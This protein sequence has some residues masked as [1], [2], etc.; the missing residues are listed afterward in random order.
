MKLIFFLVTS[1]SL[2]FGLVACGPSS[3]GAIIF[4]KGNRRDSRNGV[5]GI[6]Q[7]QINNLIN[8]ITQASPDIKDF[9]ESERDHIDILM[10]PS[11]T[12]NRARRNRT[13]PPPFSNEDFIRDSNAN[14]DITLDENDILKCEVSINSSLD[15][16]IQVHL[17]A[18]QLK[19]C[20]VEMEVYNQ[21]TN[22]ISPENL[23]DFYQARANLTGQSDNPLNSLV[24]DY[25]IY[26]RWQAYLVNRNLIQANIP[27][28]IRLSDEMIIEL[29]VM[30]LE[31]MG[32]YD[33]SESDVLSLVRGN[34]SDILDQW[35]SSQP[36]TSPPAEAS[37]RAS[38]QEF[39][40]E[41]YKL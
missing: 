35:E 15:E 30:D 39:D 16:N 5:S 4:D 33:K 41:Y 40:S 27:L 10:T 9:Y 13:S 12:T 17:L 32:I 34:I 24:I 37:R 7:N 8:K 31:N 20:Q 26:A 29:I 36:T 25:Y 23:D 11:S 19:R 3:G 22:E 1:L 18:H 6:E 38:L 21:I 2:Y 14:L 28:Y